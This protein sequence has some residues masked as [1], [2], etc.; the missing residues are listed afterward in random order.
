MLFGSTTTSRNRTCAAK[1]NV[2]L[3]RLSTSVI[4]DERRCGKIDDRLLRNRRGNIGDVNKM[5]TTEVEVN[6]IDIYDP[7]YEISAADRLKISAKIAQENLP[8]VNQFSKDVIPR[9]SFYVKYTKRF[10]DIVLSGLALL[11]TLP[12]NFVFGILTFFDVGR[13]LFFFQER[14]GKDGKIFKIVKLRNMTNETGENGDLLPAAMRVTQFGK[15]MR[16]TSLDE[17]LN[18]WSIFKG[19]MSIIGPRPLQKASRERY[20]E[21]HKMRTAV[22][23]GLLCPMLV[24]PDH[25]E[26]WI[27]QFENDIW[28]V[29]N[30]SFITD[31]KLAFCLVREVFDKES[32]SMR[33]ASTRG[34]FM[35]YEKDGSEINSKAV[36]VYYLIEALG[37]R[38]V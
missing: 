28:Y 21:R 31:V 6:Y 24:K 26:T 35:G 34:T 29:E 32:S 10:L 5:S 8:F 11:V 13:P 4:L 3:G 19:D 7:A 25:P 12:F 37:E 30:V 23:P 22:R 17:L 20:S 16:K 9:E 18:F 27:D 14:V 15:F 38:I 2:I 33:G 1:L 36:P